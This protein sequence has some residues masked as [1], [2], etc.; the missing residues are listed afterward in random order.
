M[1]KVFMPLNRI[2]NDILAR[3]LFIFGDEAPAAL[4]EMP[5]NDGKRDKVLEALELSSNQSTVSLQTGRISQTIFLVDMRLAHAEKKTT[6]PRACIANI[7]MVSA[8]FRRIFGTLFARDPVTECADLTLKLATL[9][10]A[11]YPVG[12]LGA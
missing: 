11:V 7:E 1:G 4:A 3:L 8:F 6:Y 2:R 10:V 12:N 9:V 5:V